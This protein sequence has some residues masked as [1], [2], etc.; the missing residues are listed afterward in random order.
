MKGPNVLI[1]EDDPIVAEELAELLINEGFEVLGRAASGNRAIELAK[2]KRPDLIL[3][4]VRIEG[5][6]NGIETAIVIQGHIEEVVPVVFLTALPGSRFPVLSAVDPYIY[7]NKPIE[8]TVLF[9][10]I[11]RALDKA[12]PKR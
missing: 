11:R 12:G 10:A 1:V 7:V 6:L 9:S 3:M 4:D 5:E 8:R 2:A